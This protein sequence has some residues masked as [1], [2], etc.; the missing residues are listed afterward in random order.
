MT[1]VVSLHNPSKVLELLFSL[2]LFHVTPL[3]HVQRI[4]LLMKLE[5]E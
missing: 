3:P 4:E 5:S 2:F 1:T